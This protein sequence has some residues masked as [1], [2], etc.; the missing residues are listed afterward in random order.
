[1][2]GR[3]IHLLEE[4]LGQSPLMPYHKPPAALLIREE[5]RER[6]FN[7]GCGFSSDHRVL[8]WGVD[9][10]QVED[11]FAQVVDLPLTPG[12]LAW[13]LCFNQAEKPP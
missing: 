3:E 2:C 8:S 13:G 12:R 11:L 5:R 6:L 10:G 4:G 1:M 9:I 7:M